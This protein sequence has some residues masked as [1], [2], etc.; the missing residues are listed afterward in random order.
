MGR[1]SSSRQSS[2]GRGSNG[3]FEAP[4]TKAKRTVAE[5]SVREAGHG[6]AP[7]GCATVYE[8]GRGCATWGAARGRPGRGAA[9][10]AQERGRRGRGRVGAVGLRLACWRRFSKRR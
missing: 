10:R 5:S 4:L 2:M 3:C 6:V 8:R 7:V 1:R 9:R